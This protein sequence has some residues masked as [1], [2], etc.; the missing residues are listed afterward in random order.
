MEFELPFY[1]LGSIPVPDAIYQ[2]SITSANRFQ[3]RIVLKVFN[4]YGHGGHLG[5]MTRII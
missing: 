4:I 1:L 2:V 3:R 5:H